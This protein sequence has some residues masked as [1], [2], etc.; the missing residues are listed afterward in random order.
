ML[1]NLHNIS[2]TYLLKIF[3]LYFVWRKKKG[4]NLKIKAY[5]LKTFYQFLMPQSMLLS[6]NIADLNSV[7][8]NQSVKTIS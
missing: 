3:F 1:R 4:K 5:K 2:T 8:K 6:N 7:Q